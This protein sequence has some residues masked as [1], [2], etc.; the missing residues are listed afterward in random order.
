M[1]LR[2]ARYHKR[3]FVGLRNQR[4]YHLPE[5]YVFC[6]YPHVFIHQFRVHFALTKSFNNR[7]KLI[8]LL[9][10]LCGSVRPSSPAPA[11]RHP[12]ALR[13]RLRHSLAFGVNRNLRCNVFAGRLNHGGMR[14]A[15][16][17]CHQ[18]SP[19]PSFA[20]GHHCPARTACAP[21]AARSFQQHTRQSAHRGRALRCSRCWCRPPIQFAFRSCSR[22]ITTCLT[23]RSTGH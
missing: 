17:T 20:L 22:P 7:I 6:S 13:F 16:T 19:V 10:G 12:S 14:S 8:C 4:K 18:S 9:R 5:H 1:V 21:G 3:I 2:N 23:R 11:S 15:R